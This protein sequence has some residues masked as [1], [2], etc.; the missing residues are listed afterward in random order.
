[1]LTIWFAR[2]ALAE[3]DAA[4]ALGA[5]VLALDRRREPG[6]PERRLRRPRFLPTTFGTATVGGAFATTRFTVVPGFTE[7]PP[8]GLWLITVPGVTEVV[9]SVRGR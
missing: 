3:H 7:L 1:M 5:H 4:L 8:T 6:R 9:I 2:R